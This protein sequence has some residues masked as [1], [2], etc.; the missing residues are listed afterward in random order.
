MTNNPKSKLKF[1]P[2]LYVVF[3]FA[4][5]FTIMLSGPIFTQSILLLFVQLFG[6]LL[7]MW[8]VLIMRIGN[9]N[10]VPIP[11]EKGHLVIKGPYSLIRHPMYTALFLFVIPE[12]IEGFSYLRL[13]GLLVL[14]ITLLFKLNYEEE[15]LMIKYNKYKEYK[16]KTWRLIPFVY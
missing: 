8:A 12:I 15:L 9:F 11:V 1:L 14:L 2:R 6:V 16:K 13:V 7:G 10:I 3:Q 4:A 5:L